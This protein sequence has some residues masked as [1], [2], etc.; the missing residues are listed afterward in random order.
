MADTEP[1][2][3]IQD[4]PKVQVSKQLEG[5]LNFNLIFSIVGF[6]RS[7]EASKLAQQELSR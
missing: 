2:Q 7:S 4:L 1:S 5:S 6:T 3:L